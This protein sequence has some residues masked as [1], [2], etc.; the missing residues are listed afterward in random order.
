MG[1]EEV[2]LKTTPLSHLCVYFLRMLLVVIF[3]IKSY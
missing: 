1:K 2:S 3:N